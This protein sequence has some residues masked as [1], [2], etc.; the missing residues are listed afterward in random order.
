MHT[1]EVKVFMFLVAVGIL[2]QSSDWLT[3]W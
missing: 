1:L 2:H 3:C